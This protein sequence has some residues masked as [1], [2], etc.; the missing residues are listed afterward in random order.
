MTGTGAV[1]QSCSIPGCRRR[2]THSVVE[3]CIDDGTGEAV[4]RPDSQFP[5]VCSAHVAAK[6]VTRPRDR[7]STPRRQPG[8]RSS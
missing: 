1:T 7:A 3:V 2:A 8:R 5:F 6:R 4:L